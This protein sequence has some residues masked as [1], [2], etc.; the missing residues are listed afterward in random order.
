[1]LLKL[2]DSMLKFIA[3]DALYR[4]EKGENRMAEFRFDDVPVLETTSGKLI[5]YF[6]DG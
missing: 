3:R 1:M 6:Y 5:G 4:S 2:S